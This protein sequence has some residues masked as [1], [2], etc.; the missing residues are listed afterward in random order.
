MADAQKR[1]ACDSNKPAAKVSSHSESLS[2]TTAIL[3][4]ADIPIRTV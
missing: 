1:A 2:A 3:K 4:L